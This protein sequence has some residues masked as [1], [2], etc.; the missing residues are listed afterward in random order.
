MESH[1]SLKEE[2]SLRQ[3]GS[4]ILFR[5]FLCILIIAAGVIGMKK[6]SS[7]KKPPSEIKASEK[8]VRVETM[9]ATPENV[10]VFIT[11]YGDVK[12]VDAVRIA[13]EVSGKVLEIHPA[14]EVGEVVSRGDLLFRIDPSN[15]EFRR[16]QAQALMLQ[17]EKIIDRLEKELAGAETRLKTL[18]R[19]KELARRE[20][21]RAN[22]L[23]TESKVGAKSNVESAERAYNLAVD[24]VDQ[25]KQAIE[26]YPIRIAEAEQAMASAGAGLKSAE[27][28]L[29]RCVATA[30]FKGRIKE[31]SLEKGQYVTPGTPLITLADDSLLEIHV[32]IDSTDARKWLRFQEHD[33]IRSAWFAKPDPSP[34]KIQWTE[35]M[36]GH[37]WGGRL[38]RVVSFDRRTRTMTMAVRINAVGALTGGGLPLV[39]GMFCSVRIPGKFMR[40]VVRVPRWAVGFDNTVYVARNGRLKTASVKV[41]RIQGGEAFIESGVSPG[42]QLIVTR[43]VNPLENTLLEIKPADESSS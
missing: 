29:A 21:E 18:E 26:I 34:C 17:Q 30:P 42:D 1:D 14:M 27:K 41:A 28:D 36:D 33:D 8:S 35:N 13:P 31:T 22:R 3:P 39:E 12:I 15:Y 24:Q 10:P 43:L 11:G 9:E 32:P 40:N 2:E 20:F 37:V 19:N 4:R 25:L 7:V 16:D 5:L 6:I 23:F 38:H